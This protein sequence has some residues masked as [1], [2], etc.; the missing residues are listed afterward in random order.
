[1][2]LPPADEQSGHNTHLKQLVHQDTRPIDHRHVQRTPV[3]VER[4]VEQV[5]V[6]GE[7]VVRCLRIDFGRRFGPRPI[8]TV[9]G[10]PDWGRFELGTRCVEVLRFG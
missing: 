7:I 4:K 6:E 3:L 1:M 5:V 9:A 10:A 2:S 8:R